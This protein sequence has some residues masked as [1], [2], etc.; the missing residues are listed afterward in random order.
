MK[1]KKRNDIMAAIASSIIVF[2]LVALIFLQFKT[3]DEVWEVR[4]P[5]PSYMQTK[6]TYNRI[7]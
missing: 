7:L 6:Y 3:V 4:Q 2:L 1:S 5:R